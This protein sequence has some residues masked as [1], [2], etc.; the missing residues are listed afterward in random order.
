MKNTAVIITNGKSNTEILSEL[1]AFKKKIIGNPRGYKKYI[2]RTKVEGFGR[3]YEIEGSIKKL[4]KI[5]MDL[6]MT[7]NNIS[8]I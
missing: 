4:Y 5:A 1:K 6:H 7:G 2:L 3:E 8:A